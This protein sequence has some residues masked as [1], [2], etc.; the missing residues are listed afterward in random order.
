M[1][2]NI[3][4]RGKRLICANR[5]E[6]KQRPPH[7]PS[8]HGIK[9]SAPTV[10]AKPP[11]CC[12]S[13][14]PAPTLTH[15][16]RPLLTHHHRP[17]TLTQRFGCTTTRR[18]DML[19]NGNTHTPRHLHEVGGGGGG[20]PQMRADPQYST[21]NRGVLKSHAHSSASGRVFSAWIHDSQGRLPIRAPSP[22]S[23]LP[24][25]HIMT[26]Y[27][28]TSTLKRTATPQRLTAE[29]QGLIA[30]CIPQMPWTI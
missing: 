26:G 15:H 28:L 19:T 20:W 17:T 14:L 9:S 12:G 22:G 16:L 11:A 29:L 3:V 4:Y 7:F 25:S 13:T 10:S 21:A 1:P 6:K 24:P 2:C 5:K 18:V 8:A 23:L 30:V 27:K